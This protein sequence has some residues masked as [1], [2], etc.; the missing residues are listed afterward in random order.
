[1]PPEEFILLAEE[2]GLIGHLTEN[3]LR[4]AFAAA[5]IIPDHL[6]LAANISPIQFHDPSLPAHIHAAVEQGGF[7]FNRLVLEI[8]ESALVGNIDQARAIANEL[9][10]SGIRLALDDF[11]TG[12]SSLQHLQSLPLD[13]LK[14]D[15]SF[16]R[17][18][19]NT[20]ESRK[21]VAAVIG[22]GNSL[23]LTTVAEGVESKTQ[24][25][26]LLWLGCDLGQ[27]WLYGKPMPA[28]EL[29]AILSKQTLLP[30]TGRL[31]TMASEEHPSSFI[32][33][34]PAQRLAQLQAVYDGAP[35]G[36]CFLDLNLRY[37]SVNNHLARMN[38]IPVA[39]HLGRRVSDLFPTLYAKFEPYLRRAFKG[40]SL[41]GIEVRV[42]MPN[43]HGMHSTFL[44]SYEPARDEAGE[45]VG[46]SLAVVDITERKL[47]E[48]LLRSNN[49]NGRSRDRADHV[50]REI[51]TQLQAIIAAVPIGLVITEAPSGRIVM[52]NAHA[53]N[54][55][56][57]PIRPMENIAEYRRSGAMHSN[58]HPFEPHEYPLA[59]A[60]MQ[61][62]QIGPEELLYRRGDGTCI[63]IRATASPI[64]GIHGKITGG[65]IAIQDVEE[66][67]HEMP[68]LLQL[69]SDLKREQEVHA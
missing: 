45:I 30:C 6:T 56:R 11:G 69:I 66:V 47:A 5:S 22:L 52:C 43:A 39:D 37:R 44:H 62:K 17:S 68:K 55:L 2:S 64:Y 38:N 40:E 60:L 3:I 65:V 59:R 10:S 54:V 4:R 9:K 21:I 51:E 31:R 1:V 19:T 50:S 15:A 46:V 28:E 35:M 20:R 16:I 7:P 18:M 14:V 67:E 41:S 26:M 61:G 23:G 25:D 34:L 57:R 12:Y 42:P 63:W 49:G 33:A 58:G 13:E 8:T 29:P 32:E 53:E 24:A 48:E 27:G 36:L